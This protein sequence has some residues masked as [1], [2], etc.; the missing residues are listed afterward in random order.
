[1]KAYFLIYRKPLIRFGFI[2]EGLLHKLK[3]NSISGKLLNTLKDFLYQRKQRILLNGQYSSWAA[4]EAGVPQGSI[5]GPLLFLI[6]INDL[7]D[8]LASNAKLF[9]D[10]TSLFSVVENM[11]KS[12]NE[13]NND[14]TRIST[15]TFQW[16]M[17]FNPDPTKQ[18]QEV[19]FSQKLQN[20]NHPCLIFNHNTISL[21]ESHKH[22]GI[23]LDSRLDFKEHL[24]IIF[25]KK[26][27][28]RASPQTSESI[29][30]KVIS[31]SI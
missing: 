20:T 7:S 3:E 11:T 15:W 16:K 22:L 26:Q 2:N 6:Y 30:S 27:N 12:A 28:N 17:N 8:D 10:D 14:L 31:K 18:A 1:M 5:L 21:T 4:I 25:L 13:L 19:I 24:E 9:A 23:V 29:T